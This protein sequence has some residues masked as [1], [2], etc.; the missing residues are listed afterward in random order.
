MKIGIQL[1]ENLQVV[2]YCTEEHYNA[3]LQEI[4][5][6]D[7]PVGLVE[8]G[9]LEP[10]SLLLKV[11]QNGV[12]ADAATDEAK[13]AKRSELE[14]SFN[15]SKKITLQNGNTLIIDHDT[16]ERDHFLSCLENIDSVNYIDLS[17][18]TYVQSDA[19][20]GF[21]LLPEIAQ[22]IF[23]DAFMHQVSTGFSV[24]YRLQNKAVIYSNAL[25]AIENASTEEE[26][27]AVT[28]SFI[29]PEGLLI[30]VSDKAAQ[31]LSDATLSDTA[32]AAIQAATDENG[33]VH[34]IVPINELI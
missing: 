20:L 11:Y 14:T 22:Y 28:W 23:K 34:L 15:L 27:N 8:I 18:L 33:D 3:E 21:R 1:N 29:N 16:K 9:D 13:D 2:N 24:N 31:M 5:D 30:D 26:L 25:K 19:G 4:I 17:A 32:K 6:R 7:Y 10:D 12:F